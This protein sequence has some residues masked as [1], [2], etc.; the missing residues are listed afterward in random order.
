M[1]RIVIAR[2]QI[3]LMNYICHYTRCITP[4][5]VSSLRGPSRSHWPGQHGHIRR[6]VT[7]VASRWQYCARLDQPEI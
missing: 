4:K 5:R 7:V 6:K 3:K 1:K 2:M